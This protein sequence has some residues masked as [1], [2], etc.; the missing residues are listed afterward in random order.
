MDSGRVL[1][2]NT[3]ANI[4]QTDDYIVTNSNRQSNSNIPL[5]GYT[6]D[7]SLKSIRNNGR[8]NIN[9]KWLTFVIVL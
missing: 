5:Y 7:T 3:N 4:M 1:K 2:G 8:P 6:F 9:P